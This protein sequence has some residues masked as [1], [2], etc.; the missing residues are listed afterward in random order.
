[1]RSPD[2]SFRVFATGDDLSGR[3]FQTSPCEQ[4]PDFRICSLRR[5]EDDNVD[6]LK[7]PQRLLH[8]R[9]PGAPRKAAQSAPGAGY[10]NGPDVPGLD[11]IDKSLE[12]GV[13]VVEATLVAPVPFGRKVDNVFRVCELAGF[14]HEHTARL[15]FF[16]H[17]G[18]LARFEIPG[19]GVLELEGD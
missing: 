14:E 18:G 17:A 19:I 6:V 5:F 16:T 4:P 10:C 1:C 13:D 2:F 3:L 9:P 8:A 15:H 11:L 12:A 7:P